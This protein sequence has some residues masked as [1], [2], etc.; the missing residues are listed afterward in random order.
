MSAQKEIVIVGGGVI[1]LCSAYY[2]SKAGHKITIIDKS[3]MLS[4]CSIGNAGMIVPSHFI[5]LAAPGMIAQGIKW[6]FSSESPFYVKPR[7]NFD[8]ASW[9]LKFYKAANTAKVEQAMPALR[10]ISLLSRRLF[11][12]LSNDQDLAFSFEGKGLVML[13]K[14]EQTLE[15]ETHV[16]HQ[17]NELGIKAI[18]LN[19]EEVWQKEPDLKPDVIGG[20]FF[21]GDAHCYPNAFV[22]SL[23]V[24][25]QKQGV[26]II[27]NT[28][29]KGFTT[30]KD[31]IDAVITDSEHIRADEIIVAGGS[32]SSQM[33]KT[34]GLSI[35][36]QAGKGY[37]ITLDQPSVNLN[38]PS[39]L[40]EARVAMTPMAGKLRV[41]GTME[42][43]GIN[44]DINLKRVAGIIKSVP[45]YFPTMSLQ[46]PKT[47][48][49][50]SG[51][52]PCSPDGLPYIGK[53]RKYKNLIVATG[54]A[55]MGLSLAPATGVIV[56]EL[57][58]GNK[59]SVNIDLF[60]PDRY[61]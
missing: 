6:M 48:Q 38:Y 14:S 50:W 55:M 28:E 1:G 37:S 59:P 22:Q 40:C 32:W 53:S 29:V 54:H 47:E 26:K 12:D 11:D 7:L 35:P 34:L 8:L 49:I 61:N 15:E 31:K 25:V 60:S 16:A 21:P 10:D 42:I 17:A 24:S 20:V 4:S 39:I 23:L 51:L 52:R 41:G 9:G 44:S 57:I 18:V 3:D 33:V 19:R 46:M 27:R 30:T 45:E 58:D 36:I 5:P 43:S 56:Q 2:L 13:C